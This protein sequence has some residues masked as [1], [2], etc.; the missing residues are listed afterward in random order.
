MKLK[1]LI[2]KKQI[3]LAVTAAV[4]ATGLCA[5]TAMAYFTTYATAKGGVPIEL[6]YTETK[7]QETVV[8]EMKEIKLENTGDYPCFVRVKAL[9]GD[10]YKEGLRY[11]EPSGEGKWVPGAD[12][13]YYYDEVLAPGE[14]T[15]QLDV[16]FSFPKEKP[17]DFNVIIVQE[18]TP[19][20]YD[21]DGNPYGDWNA[22][23]DVSQSVY[24]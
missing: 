23:A 10:A 5:G 6:G 8:A 12:G 21:E 13:Y 14:L 19:V 20:L 22:T 7:S 17:A 15:P 24:K 16:S 3:C 9:T 11:Q 1:R 4:L 18:N 2:S